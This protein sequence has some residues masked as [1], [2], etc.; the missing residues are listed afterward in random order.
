MAGSIDYVS[1]PRFTRR[2]TYSFS[3]LSRA[4][5]RLTK[6]LLLLSGITHSSRTSHRDKMPRANS[7]PQGRLRS[8]L[9]HRSHSSTASSDTKAITQKQA[10]VGDHTQTSSSKNLI[11]DDDF[12]ANRHFSKREASIDSLREMKEK[13]KT[14]IGR[15]MSALR[16]PRSMSEAQ[17]PEISKPLTTTNHAKSADDALLAGLDAL[18]LSQPELEML[19]RMEHVCH[20]ARV[21]RER[22]Q[23][24]HNFLA[25]APAREH[26]R[27]EYRFCNDK[28]PDFDLRLRGGGGGGGGDED[29]PQPFGGRRRRTT[30]PCAEPSAPLDDSVR[31]NAVLWWLAG[32]KMSHEGRVPT[33]G[34]LRLRREIEQANRAMVGFWGT[35]LGLRRVGPIGLMQE[36]GEGG[37]G[38]SDKKN[39]EATADLV[40]GDAEGPGTRP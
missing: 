31:P 37:E 33:M 1:F 10:F 2:R 34:E 15:R 3:S 23:N 9:T 19:R 30:L 8:W 36:G 28:R 40:T 4:C 35:V 32:G 16:R 39:G 38:E 14:S 7:S 5:L 11:A 6:A 20:A 27:P 26:Q 24:S 12:V 21:A 13:V 25:V 29:T 17:Y 18:S 22:R